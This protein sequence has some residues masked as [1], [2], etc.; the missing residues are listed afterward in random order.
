MDVYVLKGTLHETWHTFINVTISKVCANVVWMCA[1]VCACVCVS[2]FIAWSNST[3][4][5]EQTPQTCIVFT[6]YKSKISA[7]SLRVTS[8]NERAGSTRYVFS[9][10]REKGPDWPE[11][12]SVNPRCFGPNREV[13]K[14]E[15]ASAASLP[16]V[17]NRPC[18]Q[19]LRRFRST[20]GVEWKRCSWVPTRAGFYLFSP[21]AFE[22]FFY[23]YIFFTLLFFFFLPVCCQPSVCSPTPLCWKFCVWMC[24][25]KRKKK[26]KSASKPVVFLFLLR[27]TAV[28]CESKLCVVPPRFSD[29]R[30]KGWTPS[31]GFSVGCAKGVVAHTN[32]LPRRPPPPPTLSAADGGFSRHFLHPH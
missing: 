14:T 28:P 30:L 16:D 31:R 25:K 27:L 2:G 20:S 32:P 8:Q 1:S 21:R 17:D 4:P 24:L 9:G 22:G 18:F 29:C 11:R 5:F 15:K 26:K 7:T 10:K 19:A 6:D 3:I 13:R 12:S 23:I